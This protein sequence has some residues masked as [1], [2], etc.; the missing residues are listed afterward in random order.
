MDGPLG[1]TQLSSDLAAGQAA[2]EPETG[3]GSVLAR[4]LFDGFLK[5][6]VQRGPGVLAGQPGCQRRRQ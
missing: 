1:S 3:Y 2:E 4:E 5:V 6:E